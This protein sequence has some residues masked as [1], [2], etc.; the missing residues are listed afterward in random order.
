MHDEAIAQHRE[1]VALTG[2]SSLDKSFLGGAY[3]AAGRTAEAR[4]ILQD[5]GQRS[6][7]GEWPDASGRSYIHMMLGE[8]DEAIAWLE[9]AVEE[10]SAL[11]TWMRVSP[12]L[13]PLRSDAR[14]H[15]LLRRLNFP[16]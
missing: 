5:L 12:H 10:R 4:S 8:M 9:R 13:D 1:A 6:A 16:S 3:A 14:F 7:A 15:E 2:D 11:V